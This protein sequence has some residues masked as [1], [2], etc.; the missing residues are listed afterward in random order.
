MNE[1]L[2]LLTRQW[3]TRPLW[4]CP[5]RRRSSWSHLYAASKENRNKY[6]FKKRQKRFNDTDWVFNCSGFCK[7]RYILN[8]HIV[9]L[10]LCTGF[11]LCVW[12]NSSSVDSCSSFHSSGSSTFGGSVEHTHKG[13][14]LLLGCW[15]KVAMLWPERRH[16]DTHWPTTGGLQRCF[17]LRKMRYSRLGLWVFWGGRS[18]G[19][20]F[21]SK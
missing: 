4:G 19:R 7:S 12:T 18:G 15:C 8:T 16:N 3:C 1:T 9:V 2:Y 11:L 17:S 14:H 10:T 5:V 21:G 13:S 20:R 6:K